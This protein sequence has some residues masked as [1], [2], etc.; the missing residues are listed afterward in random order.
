[1]CQILS[2]YE[3]S[4][5]SITQTCMKRIIHTQTLQILLFKIYWSEWDIRHS[6][7]IGDT[8]GHHQAPYYIIRKIKHITARWLWVAHQKMRSSSP[9]TA[10]V[11]L[12]KAPIGSMGTVSWLALCSDHNILTSWDM[13]RIISLY[14][15][16]LCMWQIK[17][18]SSSVHSQ[19]SLPLFFLP[20]QKLTKLNFCLSIW[21]KGEVYPS[22][23]IMCYFRRKHW[24]HMFSTYTLQ[25]VFCM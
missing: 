2:W 20:L 18:S 23:I 15:N 4:Q 14:C 19:C 5:F 17:A 6:K 7:W 12:S 1:M 22:S 9:S 3:M 8:W 10:T 13:Q 21:L 24:L 11:L 16:A 25:N